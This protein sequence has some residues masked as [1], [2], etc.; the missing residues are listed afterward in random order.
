MGARPTAPRGRAVV[1][2]SNRGPVS[3]VRDAD[4]RVVPKRGAGGLVAALTGA[5]QLSGGLWLA[6]AMTEADREHAGAGGHSIGSG[7]AAYQVRYL[8]FDPHTYDG[9]YNGISNRVLWFLHHALWDVVEQPMF[10]ASTRSAWAAYERVNEAFADALHEE[11]GTGREPAYLLQDYHLSLVPAMLRERR[12]EARIAHFM[13]IPFAGPSY[14]RI[15]PGF[16]RDE[17]LAGMLGADVVGFHAEAW[18]ESFLLGCR[19]LPGA[20]VDLRRRLVRWQGRQVRVRMYPI[21]IDAQ[22]LKEEAV[23]DPVRAAARRVAR[24]SGDRKLI[25]RVDRVELSKN[26]LRGFLAYEALLRHRPSWRGKVTFLALLNPSRAGIREYRT[27]L[28]KSRAVADR[29]NAK[30]GRDGWQPVRVRVKDDFATV[31]AAY[32]RYD[33][34][35]VNPVFDGM[36]LVAKEGPVINE[37]DGVLILSENAGASDELGQHALSIDPFDL[38]ATTEALEHALTMPADERRRRAEALRQA[39]L[40]NRL[41]DWVN[42]QVHDLEE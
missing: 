40:A 28:Q 31:L 10:D 30:Y 14:L 42:R 39:V 21:S 3:F 27:Y 38:L 5:L 8:A 34:L 24:W 20:R 22:A 23:R 19:S 29:I 11:G 37:R 1:I 33:A 9:F 7:G 13:H 16:I 6:S 18:A 12:P 35:L 4:G 26:I 36:N 25:L 2:A 41:Q 32:E 15:L 17:L